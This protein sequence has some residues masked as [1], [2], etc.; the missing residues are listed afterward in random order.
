MTK[1]KTEPRIAPQIK[2]SDVTE[3]Y[4]GSSYK[5]MVVNLPDSM[6]AQDINDSPEIWALVQ[7]NHNKA[8]SEHDEVQLRSREWTIW[9]FVNHASNTGVTLYNIRKASKPVRQAELYRDNTYEVR[10]SHEG[11]AYFR[12]SDGIRM[13]TASWP[14]AE[15][16]KAALLREMYPSRVAS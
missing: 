4:C 15:S 8:L 2:P 14:N 9:A 1:V 11:F 12:V 6:T 13:S 16:C 10:W 5:Q 3:N 7:A